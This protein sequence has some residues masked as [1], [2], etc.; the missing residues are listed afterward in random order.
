MF[1]SEDM[2]AS[3]IFPYTLFLL[4]LNKV[5]SSSIGW[6]ILYKISEFHGNWLGLPGG[7]AGKESACNVRDPGAILGSGRS[8]IEGNGNPLQYSCLG[9]PMDRG[10][11]QPTTEILMKPVGRINIQHLSCTWTEEWQKLCARYV[12]AIIAASCCKNDGE[13]P[14]MSSK[15]TCP[16]HLKEQL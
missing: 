5:L 16:A 8:P 15:Q 6:N 10:A 9:N 13:N 14:F 2:N 12:V 3:I 1:P 7:S 4:I 11:W